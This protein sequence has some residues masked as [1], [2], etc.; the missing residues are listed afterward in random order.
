M[1]VHGEQEFEFLKVVKSGDTITTEGHI[2]EIYEKK[3]LDF[4][5]METISTNQQREIV[6]RALWKMVIRR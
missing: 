2:A 5:S 1:I 4:I 6:T 3:G